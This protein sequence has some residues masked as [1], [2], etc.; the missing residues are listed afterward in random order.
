[1]AT[2][3]ELKLLRFIDS[4]RGHFQPADRGKNTEIRVFLVYPP[5]RRHKRPVPSAC[6]DTQ[7]SNF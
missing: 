1:M 5:E 7:K 4:A 6:K 2:A 3:I